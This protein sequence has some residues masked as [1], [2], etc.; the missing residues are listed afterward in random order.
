MQQV[1]IIFLKNDIFKLAKS[2][3]HSKQNCQNR[4]E[5]VFSKHALKP[6]FPLSK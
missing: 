3:F 2:Y 5:D 4:C 1:K 6:K